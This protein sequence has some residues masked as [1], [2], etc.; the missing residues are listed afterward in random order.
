MYKYLHFN[1]TN[2]KDECEEWKDIMKNCKRIVNL[3]NKIPFAIL[4]NSF[5]LC[6]IFTNVVYMYNPDCFEIDIVWSDC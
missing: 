1:H 6:F 2:I 5:I 4:E 3:R